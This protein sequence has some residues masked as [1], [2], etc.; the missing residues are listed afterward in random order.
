[1][2]DDHYKDIIAFQTK[3]LWV[4]YLGMEDEQDS[5]QEDSEDVPGE[6]VPSVWVYEGNRRTSSDYSW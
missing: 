6:E 5:G 4:A 2:N 3:M 1:M